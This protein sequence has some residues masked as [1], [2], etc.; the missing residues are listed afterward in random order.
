MEQGQR[1]S[2]S[3]RPWWLL[4]ALETFWVNTFRLSLQALQLVLQNIL[5]DRTMPLKGKKLASLCNCQKHHMGSFWKKEYRMYPSAILQSSPQTGTVMGMQQAAN[6]NWGPWLSFWKGALLYTVL[7]SDSGTS[8]MVSGRMLVSTFSISNLRN[9]ITNLED[10]KIWKG[11]R[12][13]FWSNC[14]WEIYSAQRCYRIQNQQVSTAQKMRI[15]GG[16]V[17]L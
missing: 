6:A 2:S 10:S 17:L 7:K 12:E 15:P 9:N 16:G 13:V 11:C 5:N 1:E 14:L 3:G 8:S 4:A